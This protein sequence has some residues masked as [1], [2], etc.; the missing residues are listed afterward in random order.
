[1]DVDGCGSQVTR[2]LVISFDWPTVHCT[3]LADCCC[4]YSVVNV[5]Q[6]V[7]LVKYSRA[8]GRLSQVTY[9]HYYAASPHRPTTYV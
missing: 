6:S 5:D 4:Q 1:M 8:K 2:L 3:L 7:S 9:C